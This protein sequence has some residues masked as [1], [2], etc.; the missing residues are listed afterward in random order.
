MYEGPTNTGVVPSKK[1]NF[2]VELSIH[3]S[4]STKFEGWTEE[5]EGVPDTLNIVPL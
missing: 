3:K 5:T 2:L 1:Y 4:P